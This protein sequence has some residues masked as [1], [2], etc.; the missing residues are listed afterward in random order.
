MSAACSRCI[1]DC[2]DALKS[3]YLLLSEV[4]VSLVINM[5][6]QKPRKPYQQ[7]AEF[8]RGRIVGMQEGGFSYKKL[9]PAC[10]VMRQQRCVFVRNG[11]RRIKQSENQWGSGARNSTRVRDDRHL[12]CMAVTDRTASSRVLAQLW[13]IATGVLLSSS[14]IRRH[15]LQYELRAKVPLRRITLSLNHRRLRF[16]LA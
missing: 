9:Q 3:V 16:T 8:V 1:K 12:I 6:C 14:T 2:K 7:L 13:S 15:L 4:N 10:S 5:P 11:Q